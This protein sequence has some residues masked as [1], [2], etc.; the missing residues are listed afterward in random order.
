MLAFVWVAVLRRRPRECFDP[1]RRRWR[2]AAPVKRR[3][4]QAGQLFDVPQQRPL[5]AVA[6]RNRDARG[7][8]PR[9][10]ADPVNI[11]F[12]HFGN[13]MRDAVDVE[14]ARRDVGCDEG[15]DAAAAKRV[16]RTFPLALALVTVNRASRDPAV[17]EMLGDLVGA[18]FRP[19]ENERP[20]HSRIAEKLERED[21]ACGSFR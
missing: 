16:Q 2:S 7:A 3:Q 20:G 21:R 10:A 1:L 14:A 18:A 19:C 5:G 17:I 6:K 11:G 9:R 4:L 13:D 15:A 8:S 12:R